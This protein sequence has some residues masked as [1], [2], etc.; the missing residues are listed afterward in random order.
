MTK[1]QYR[2]WTDAEVEQLRAACMKRMTVP[3][4]QRFVF[5]YRSIHSLRDKI[6]KL[7]IGLFALTKAE[8]APPLVRPVAEY[9]EPDGP[10][11]AE[12]FAPDASADEPEPAFLDRVLKS[13][14]RSIEKAKA[15]RHV[16]LR[17]ASRVPIAITISS[18]WHV[19]PQGTDLTGLLAYADFVAHTPRLY[20]MAVGDLLDNPIKH[21]GGSVGQIADDLRLLDILVGRFKGKLLGTTSGNHDDWSKLLAGT[22]H[23]LTLA[24][25]HRI[26]YAPDELLWQVEIV[27]PDDAEHV[28]A[29]YTIATRHQWRRHSNLNPLH[30]C[31][32]W[33]QEEGPNWDTVPD[34]LAIGHNHVAAHGA[35]QYERRDIWGLRMGAWQIDSAYARAKGFA[36]YRSTAP[37][38]VLP[39]TRETRVVAFSDPQ[40]AIQYMNGGQSDA[41]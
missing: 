33:L 22:D 26:H 36:R 27:D 32:T 7:H 38:V 16:R 4:I 18:D 14:D 39:P 19:A 29:S 41:A 8:M 10:A 23:L 13:A 2:P 11:L 9:R 28:T 1:A 17:I 21:K 20:A 15:Q 6:E 34:V 37:T 12:V 3:D 35:H 30:A 25:R 31:W 5:P 40:D 24:R